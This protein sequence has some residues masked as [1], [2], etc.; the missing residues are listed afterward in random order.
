MLMK[1]MIVELHAFGIP[2][3]INI[4]DNL[5]KRYNNYYKQYKRPLVVKN[6]IG[7]RLINIEFIVCLLFEDKLN[8]F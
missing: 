5:G 2:R 1:K 7:T 3:E 4:G 8:T 6:N